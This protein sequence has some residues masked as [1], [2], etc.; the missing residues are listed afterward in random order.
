MYQPPASLTLPH[1]RSAF[2]DGLR[3]LTGGQTDID[4]QPVTSMDSS[5]V[6]ALLGWKK[7]AAAGGKTLRFHHLPAGL[8][9]LIALYGVADIINAD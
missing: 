1:V 8:S 4:F 7:A 5:A 9:S 3:A 6:A 2:E